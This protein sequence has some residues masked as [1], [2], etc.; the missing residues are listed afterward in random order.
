ERP[1]GMHGWKKCR[2]VLFSALLVQSSVFHFALS[3][4]M[5]RENHQAS[6]FPDPPV[7]IPENQSTEVSSAG[8][9]NQI[10]KPIFRPHPF[11]GVTRE[12]TEWL[13]QFELTATINSWDEAARLQVLNLM[14]QGKARQVFQG[15]NTDIKGNSAKVKAFPHATPEIGAL[16]AV[17]CSY[18]LP[19][20]IGDVPCD[21]LIDCGAQVSIIHKQVWDQINS[22]NP[23]TMQTC[24]TMLTVANGG[25]M[26]VIGKWKTVVTI[27]NLH[28]RDGLHLN[29]DGA[30]ALDALAG[31][32]F[33]QQYAGTINIADRSC[34]LMGRKFS[35]IASDD[36]AQI[37]QW[38]MAGETSL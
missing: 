36:G 14:L 6:V 10:H 30:A 38:I 15:F 26:H 20:H 7:L 35:L 1:P 11:D 37:Q 13:E 18:F 19:I 34:T 28:L 3:Y 8:T 25:T 5:E 31:T 9:G 22:K 17:G 12:W 32:D 27:Q 29:D 24:H 4:N 2:K 16:Q 23:Q 33:L 21:L